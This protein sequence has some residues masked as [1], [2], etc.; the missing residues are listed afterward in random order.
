MTTVT[1]APVDIEGLPITPS[2]D[3]SSMVSAVDQ[4][5]ALTEVVEFCSIDDH[6]EMSDEYS[7]P[8][9][10]IAMREHEAGCGIVFLSNS[11]V[12]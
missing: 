12:G 8:F 5:N 11:T 7:D 4:F 6:T 3:L 2:L 9:H 10:I 1:A